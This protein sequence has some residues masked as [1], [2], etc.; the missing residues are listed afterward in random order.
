MALTS[1]RMK[2]VYGKDEVSQKKPRLL[3]DAD[4]I[5]YQ[6]G[7]SHD[8]KQYV[9]TDGHK[10]RLKIRMN[11][12]CKE[13]DLRK[14]EL[15]VSL[16]PSPIA[17]VYSDIDE[18]I[19]LVAEVCKSKDISLY[20]TRGK[21]FR[22]NVGTIQ[23][24]KWRRK[25]T[26]RP[27]HYK[28]IQDYLVDE[29]SAT[30]QAGLEADD[31]IGMNATTSDIIASV[32]KDFDTFPNNRYNWRTGATTSVLSHQAYVNFYSMCL[33]GDKADD[34]QGLFG[35]GAQ[36]A[37]VKKLRK[38]LTEKEMFTSVRYLYKKYFGRY[39]DQF[40]IETCTLL[41]ILRGPLF[42]KAKRPQWMTYYGFMTEEELIK[43]HMREFI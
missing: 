6:L 8:N 15:V 39:A 1:L 13:N 30:F 28:A 25:L 21:T 43:D 20:L 14:D 27:F 34:I 12:Y 3:I 42:T 17:E 4:L 19:Q 32:D 37:H 7:H 36:S 31:L 24:Y 33:L 26:P 18:L 38:M 5:V 22:H 11:A 2:E 29:Y 35:V 10:E 40:L 41:Y 16:D 9:A 23:E